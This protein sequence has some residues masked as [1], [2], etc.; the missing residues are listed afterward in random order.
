MAFPS[1][2]P[3]KEKVAKSDMKRSGFGETILPAQR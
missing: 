3:E 2:K 1:A